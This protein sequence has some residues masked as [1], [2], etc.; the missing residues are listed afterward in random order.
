LSSSVFFTLSKTLD[1]FFSPLTWGLLLCLVGLFKK[2]PWLRWA[3]ALAA[4]ELMFFSLDPVSNALLLH[5]ERQA[6]RTMRQGLTYDAIILL[7][8]AVDHGATESHGAVSYNDNVERLLV[9]YDLLRTG[10]AKNI[11]VS[12]G[13]ERSG[14]R[15][16]EAR[17]LAEQLRDWGIAQRRI[18]LEPRA[19]NTR[20]NAVESARLVKQHGYRTLLL[21]TSGYHM[22]RALDCFRGVGLRVDTLPVDFR[23]FSGARCCDWL[24]RADHLDVSTLALREMFGRWV[25]RVRGY[26]KGA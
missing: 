9:S 17:Q 1:V 23:A 3:P 15:V 20:G 11:I 2:W 4:A 26:G 8:G 14:D 24:P 18:V 22:P 6:P 10:R 16:N 12:G 19:V 13:Y 5:L 7:G 25:Y 21:V